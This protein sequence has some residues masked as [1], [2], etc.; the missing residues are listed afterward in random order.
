MKF[1]EIP[2]SEAV[3]AILAHA[4]RT[5]G[6]NFSKG[7]RLTADDVAKL[8]AAGVELVDELGAP[9]RRTS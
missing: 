1:G 8:Q 3:G 4:Y 5:K 9:D 7:R 2:L 6:I